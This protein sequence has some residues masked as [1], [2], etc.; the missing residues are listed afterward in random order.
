[1]K[2]LYLEI[3]GV[4]SV[5]EKQT[6]DFEKVSKSGIFGV[7]G[8]TGSGK[9][10]ILDSIVLA[11]YG[12]ITGNVDNKDFINIGCNFARVNL[13]FSVTGMGKTTKYR[14]ERSYKLDKKRE[15]ATSSAKLWE[16]TDEG[17]ICLSEGSSKVSKK[18]EEEIIGLEQKEFLRCIALPQGAFADFLNLTRS[19]RLSFIG[20]LFGLEKYGKP[21]AIKVSLKLRGLIESERVLL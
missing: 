13:L 2:P 4:K 5:A 11:I 7:F 21:L 10:T 12:S 18:L 15:N 19:H 16:V 9:T 6:I 14:V 3:E 20:K 1:M 17:E 8:K